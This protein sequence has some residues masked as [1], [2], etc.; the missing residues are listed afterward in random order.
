MKTTINNLTLDTAT[1]FCY[2]IDD[3]VLWLSVGAIYKNGDT[4][5]IHGRK[6]LNETSVSETFHGEYEK[7]KIIG[8]DEDGNVIK[9]EIEKVPYEWTEYITAVSYI[10]VINYLIEDIKNTSLEISNANIFLS[11]DSIKATGLMQVYLHDCF[12]YKEDKGNMLEIGNGVKL[13][14]GSFIEL[15]SG[16]FNSKIENNGFDGS[17]KREMFPANQEYFLKVGKSDAVI[18]SY[19]NQRGYIPTSCM[20]ENADKDVIIIIRGEA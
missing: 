6:P 11:E 14:S 17:N 4:F 16:V 20:K 7:Y 1:D 3:T 13:S 9:G 18:S 5:Y 10:D 2:K 19:T 15:G 12:F 8:E